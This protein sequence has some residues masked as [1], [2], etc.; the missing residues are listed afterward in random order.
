[1]KSKQVVC[2]GELL[3]DCLADQLGK[4]V[5]EVT[6]W[7]EYPGGAPANVACA[8]AKLGTS[9]A[10]VG[11]VGADPEGNALVKLLQDFQIDVSG[12]QV[13]SD[14]ST[15]KV[16]VV[17]TESGEPIFGGFGDKV[18]HQF[19]DARLRADRLPL[20]MIAAADFLVIGTIALAYR[21]SRNAVQ[22]AISHCLPNQTQIALDVNWRPMFWS[23]P[24]GARPM[25]QGILPTVSWLKMSTAEAEWLFG[26]EDLDLI[27]MDLPTAKGIILTQGDQGCYYHIGPHQGHI[28]AF[29]VSVQDTTGAGDA[30]LAGFLHQLCQGGP[31]ILEDANAVKGMLRYATAVGALTTMQPGA[32]AAQ[33]TAERVAEFLALHS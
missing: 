8:L 3:I 29:P 26:T 7:T 30:F 16:Y 12:V 13:E 9:V 33:P 27:A 15:R 32:I 2:M 24:E 19:A 11:A 1:M 31:Q 4:P 28:P 17:R 21:D 6:S 5:E 20:D 23:Y 14:C 18:N 22:S 10:F 25:I